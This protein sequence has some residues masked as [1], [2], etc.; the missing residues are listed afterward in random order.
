MEF[1]GRAIRVA[2]SMPH[3]SAGIYVAAQLLRSAT[4]PF[5]HL[6]EAEGAESRDDCVR[7]GSDTPFCWPAECFGFAGLAAVRGAP[8]SRRPSAASRRGFQR[9]RRD[10]EA[11]TFC[12]PAECALRTER[13]LRDAWVWSNAPGI[14]MRK[15]RIC[16]KE[17]R[18]ARRWLRLVQRPPL[19]AKPALLDSVVTEADELVRLFAASIRPAQNNRPP[20]RSKRPT[21]TA[22]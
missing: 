1:A 15:L 10:A 22:Q 16:Y 2:E 6:G 19:V 18:E 21:L 8:A 12:W 13:R 14:F 5:G 20:S 11:S 4:S 7:D 3:S 17:L 9:L